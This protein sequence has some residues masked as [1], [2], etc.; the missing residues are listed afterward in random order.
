MPFEIGALTVELLGI[1]RPGLSGRE[2]DPR[3]R[4]VAPDHQTHSLVLLIVM[5]ASQNTLRSRR[6]ISVRRDL[7]PESY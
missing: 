7:M 6:A 4:H 2:R 1:P 5:M 3:P